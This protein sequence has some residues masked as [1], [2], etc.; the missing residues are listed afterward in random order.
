MRAEVDVVMMTSMVADKVEATP[1][2]TSTLVVVVG[3]KMIRMEAA[4]TIDDRMMAMAG[5]K[6]TVVD[7]RMIDTEAAILRVPRAVVVTQA[8]VA[9]IST[10]TRLCNRLKS[11]GPAIAVFSRPLWVS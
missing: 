1:V 11:T 7:D 9:V 3:D 2:G 4:E 10:T 6:A 8:A 5:M